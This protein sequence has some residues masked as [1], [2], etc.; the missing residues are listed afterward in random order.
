MK[1]APIVLIVYNRLSHTKR[2]IEALKQNELAKDSLLFIF[3]DGPKPNDE[4]CFYKVNEVRNY[5]KTIEGFKE[6]NVMESPVNQGVDRAI[7][8]GI[9]YVLDIYGKCIELEDDVIPHPWFLRFINECLEKY[10]DDKRIWQIG[11][12]INNI[13]FPSFF[14]QDVVMI[15]RY[16]SWG[17]GMWKDRWDKIKWE[18][19]EDDYKLFLINCK[20]S[21]DFSRGGSDLL[22]MLKH[23]HESGHYSYDILFQYTMS[24]NAGYVVM[25]RYSLSRNIGFDGTGSHCMSIDMSGIISPSP[26]GNMYNLK[27][28]ESIKTS[29][30]IEKRYKEFQDHV[31]SLTQKIKNKIRSFIT[32]IL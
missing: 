16:C 28:P 30:L 25:P 1:L 15:P 20:L 2:V 17:F 27:L 23:Q 21:S 3:S 29:R 22:K 4:E 19:D 26:S 18:I 6:V 12:F 10:K 8:N 32:R 14:L 5:L 11:S 13:Q 31:P 24:K 7:M 9:S